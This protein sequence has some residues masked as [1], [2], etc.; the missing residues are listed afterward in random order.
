MRSL[1]SPPSMLRCLTA[2]LLLTSCSGRA[3]P[4]TAQ[5]PQSGAA[6]D[7]EGVPPSP[8]ESP[9]LVVLITVD[10]LRADYYERFRPQLTG[11]LRRLY[12]G[13][14]VFTNAF[15]D[16]ANT[17][18]APGHASTLSGRFPRSTGIVS[19][20]AGV[21]DPQA[22]LVGGLGSGASPFRFRGSTLVDWMRVRDP[23]VR[24]LSVS[25]K[26]RGAILPLGRAKQQVFWYAG[27]T[28]TFV[29][30]TYYA[31]TLPQWVRA[32]NA[33]RLPAS[34][35]DRTWSLLLDPSKYTEPDSVPIEAAG[36]SVTFPHRMPDDTAQAL[37]AVPGTPWMDDITVALALE[38]V[39]ALG[40][41]RG[42]ASDVLAVSL[43][44]TDYIGHAYGPYSREI[45][46][47]ILRLDRAIGVLLDSL[48][49]MVPAS[50]TI[51]ALTSDHGVA[52]YPGT[53]PRGTPSGNAVDLRPMA[54]RFRTA[55]AARGAD[56]MAFR[57]ED[58]TLYVDRPS[59]GR[60]KVP[61]DSLLRAFAAE[62]RRDPSVH[63]VHFVRDLPREAAN[64]VSARRWLHMLPPDLPIE[65]VVTLRP[66]DLWAPLR[67][68]QHG[69]PHDYDAH[70]PLIFYGAPFRAGR[71]SEMARTV[72]L[73]TTLAWAV[74]TIPTEPVDGRVLKSAVR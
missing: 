21:A 59:L 61:V 20:S 27:R 26:D 58:G 37:G 64:D 56:S 65:L 18:T 68:A 74:G 5:T 46:D 31:D 11:G 4:A 63:R 13:G 39:R 50:Q 35:T 72:D 52:P 45:H 36:V 1:S 60:A 41:G 2:A 47:Q 62:L 12:E 53:A 57:F 51:V 49:V 69:S 19:N 7:R 9:R 44:A 38:G 54:S 42:N 23:R 17:E 48:A 25:T 30:S 6:R 40:L 55:L 32:F 3:A 73:G 10:Q 70:V 22:P 15:Q 24:A 33:R 16:H 28:G 66:Y 34:F 71:Y 14:A 8:A 43:S 67:Y 29:T